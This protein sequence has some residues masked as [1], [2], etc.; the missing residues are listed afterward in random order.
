MP[1]ESTMHRVFCQN[2][3]S[4]RIG[5]GLTQGAMADRLGM[6]QPQYAKI[7]NGTNVPSLH[8]IER[9]T[10]SLG[11]SAGE[12]LGTLRPEKQLSAVT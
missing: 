2:L 3:R 8:T 7:E 12:L 4:L 10:V 1:A 6:T 11:V 5:G 9:I